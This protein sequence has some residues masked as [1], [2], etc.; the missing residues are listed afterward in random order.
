MY[1]D[2]LWNR[3]PSR[4]RWFA[5]KTRKTRTRRPWWDFSSFFGWNQVTSCNAYLYEKAFKSIWTYVDFRCRLFATKGKIKILQFKIPL[6]LTLKLVIFIGLPF[7][8]LVSCFKSILRYIFVLSLLWYFQQLFFVP[9][10]EFW[11]KKCISLYFNVAKLCSTC[12]TLTPKKTVPIIN[13]VFT[14]LSCCILSP[15]QK[16]ANPFHVKL[17]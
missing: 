13:T 8:T 16:P 1:L 11:G 5:G 3:S 12:S 6:K 15:S 2:Y 9:L 17:Q 14:T 4:L 7:R 10:L